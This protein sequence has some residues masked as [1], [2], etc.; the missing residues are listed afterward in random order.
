MKDA[1][2][3]TFVCDSAVHKIIGYQYCVILSKLPDKNVHSHQE[4]Y[5]SVNDTPNLLVFLCPYNKDKCLL[6]TFLVGA[7]ENY[8]CFPLALYHPSFSSYD[9]K[10][11]P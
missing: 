11:P 9:Y 2:P 8:C 10:R 3:G 7:F 5:W 6:V 1:E 4:K